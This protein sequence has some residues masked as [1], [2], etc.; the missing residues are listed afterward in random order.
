MPVFMVMLSGLLIHYLAMGLLSLAMPKHF[1]QLNLDP[2]V[3]SEQRLL[4]A[5]GWVLLLAGFYPII[6]L[7][8]AAT[9]TVFGLGLLSLA[10]LLW[11]VL[12]SLRP[13]IAM[14][15]LAV[16]ACLGL[17]LVLIDLFAIGV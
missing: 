9:G 16:A 2:L 14:V 15:S 12:F 5:S 11:I 13:L 7:W 1:A 4:R 10:G 3:V 17:A 6:Q 8:G